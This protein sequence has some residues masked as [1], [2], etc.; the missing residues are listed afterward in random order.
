MF[1]AKAGTIDRNLFHFDKSFLLKLLLSPP[2]NNIRCIIRI[3]SNTT[4]S[5]RRNPET[6][7]SNTYRDIDFSYKAS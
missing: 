5:A 6:S 2:K 3:S 4:A 1:A 7:D